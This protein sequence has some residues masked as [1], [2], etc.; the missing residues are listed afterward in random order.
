MLCRVNEVAWEAGQGGAMGG[1][2][3]CYLRVLSVMVVP[4]LTHHATKASS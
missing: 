4:S 2:V 1:S 3:P